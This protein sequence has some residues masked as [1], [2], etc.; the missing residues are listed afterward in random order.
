[1]KK[2]LL[3]YRHGFLLIF[4]LLLVIFSYREADTRFSYDLSRFF[5][6]TDHSKEEEVIVSYLLQM[7]S[8]NLS[9]RRKKEFARVIV[10]NSQKLQFPDKSMLGE[11]PPI[12]SLFFLAWA[13][14]RTNLQPETPK[15]YGILALSEIFIREFELSSGVKINRDYD[16]K[17]DSIQFKMVLLKFKEYLAEGK[18]AKEAYEKIYGSNPNANEWETLIQ[19]YK[20]VYEYV[21]SENKP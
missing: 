10:R 11:Y 19:N 14:T 21:I 7:E 9:L 8:S 3:K 17:N 5:E 1:M 12:P 4:P 6:K 16:V 2:I 13:K 18:S 15:G 20:K